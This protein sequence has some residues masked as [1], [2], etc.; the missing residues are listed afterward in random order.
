MLAFLTPQRRIGGP[1]KRITTVIGACLLVFVASAAAA[2]F[3]SGSYMGTTDQGLAIRLK[4]D[5]TKMLSAHYTANYQCKNPDGT[6]GVAKAQP[7]SLGTS[8]IKSG[9]KIDSH[10]QSTDGRDKTH[11]VVHFNGKSASGT[12]NEHYTNS[13][14]AMCHTGTVTFMLKLQ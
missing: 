3:Q 1:V 2:G 5:Q 7:T 6:S 10:Q 8:A 9:D 14:G 12:L 13:H 4:V 11:F